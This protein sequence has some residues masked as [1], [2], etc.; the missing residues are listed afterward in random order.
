VARHATGHFSSAAYSK[1]WGGALPRR[2]ESRDALVKEFD[3]EIREAGD[4]EITI[5]SLSSENEDR[6]P[7]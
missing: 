3:G 6:D 1:L 4:G 5:S 2:N 7:R